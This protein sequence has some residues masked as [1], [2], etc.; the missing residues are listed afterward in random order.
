MNHTRTRWPSVARMRDFLELKRYFLVETESYVAIWLH[1]TGFYPHFGCISRRALVKGS[2][3]LTCK[4]LLW[5]IWFDWQRQQV[6]CKCIKSTQS[7]RVRQSAQSNNSQTLS[8]QWKKEV[9]IYVR[10][11]FG[12]LQDLLLMHSNTQA[13][14]DKVLLF[15]SQLLNCFWR[16]TTCLRFVT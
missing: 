1:L 4:Y 5:R 13:Y 8:Y 15:I 10:D 9:I 14:H 16:T 3:T 6:W 7:L 2:W 11:I 12:L